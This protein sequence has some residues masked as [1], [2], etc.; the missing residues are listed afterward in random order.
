[1]VFVLHLPRFSTNAQLISRYSLLIGILT[2]LGTFTMCA[3]CISPDILCQRR[4]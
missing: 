1:M 3:C 4:E 2:K